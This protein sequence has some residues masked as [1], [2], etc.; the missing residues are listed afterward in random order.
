MFANLESGR[1]RL[2]A[3]AK[4]HFPLESPDFRQGEQVNLTL[5]RKSRVVGT[6][7]T[8]SWMPSKSLQVRL[9][10]V[11]NPGVR[12]DDQIHNHE[13]KKY[14]FFDWVRPGIYNVQ[15]RSQ[16]FPDPFVRIDGLEILA[17]QQ[18][19]HP[20][21]QNLNLGAFLYRFE[22]TAV[23]ERGNP[24]KP[25]GPL[26]AQIMRPDGR[27]GFVGFPWRGNRVEIIAVSPQLTHCR[28]KK[29]L[30]TNIR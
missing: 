25:S 29:A 27:T 30:R 12:R 17:G 18:D 22:V 8:P 15:I 6:V 24:I 19:L 1:Y 2:R 13:G 26:L 28:P 21:L 5:D 4:E 20:R 3:E 14:I 10:S 23:D 11:D 16:D 7:L 9:Q